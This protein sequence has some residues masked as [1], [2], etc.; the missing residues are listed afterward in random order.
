MWPPAFRTGPR[1]YEGAVVK[2]AFRKNREIRGKFGGNSCLTH[3]SEERPGGGNILQVH[4]FTM[5]SLKY[6]PDGAR[7][8]LTNYQKALGQEVGGGGDPEKI[9]TTSF[10]SL[11]FS[12]RGRGGNS[13]GKNNSGVTQCDG[14]NNPEGRPGVKPH[15]PT[16]DRGDTRPR[17]VVKSSQLQEGKERNTRLGIVGNLAAQLA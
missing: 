12:T 8:T 10:S 6:A 13:G 9:E 3:P 7:T 11:A 17:E 1:L 4:Y 14:N 2:A 15:Q 16:S 5:T